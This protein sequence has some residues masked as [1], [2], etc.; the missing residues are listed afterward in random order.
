MI[1]KVEDIQYRCV[2]P[3]AWRYIIS[4]VEGIKYGPVTS[5]IQRRVFST[6]LPKLLKG[7]LIW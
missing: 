7:Y 6:L 3:S 2:T 5:S 1:N 4:T